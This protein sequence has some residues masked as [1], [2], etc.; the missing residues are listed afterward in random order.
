M[1]GLTEEHILTP[2][3]VP[4][5]AVAEPLTGDEIAPA[6]QRYLR[7]LPPDDDDWADPLGDYDDETETAALAPPEAEPDLESAVDAVL[8]EN[9]LLLVP[10]GRVAEVVP[11]DL[12]P[13][14]DLYLYVSKANS[15][16]FAQHMWVFKRAEAGEL[17]LAHFWPVSTGRERREGYFTTTPT[18]LYKLDPHR[19]KRIHYSSV[20]DGARMPFAM[21]LDYGY[22]DR[23]SGLAIHGTM[24][25]TYGRLGSRASGGC[26]RVATDNAR[27]LFNLI[28]GSYRGQVPAFAFDE[29]NGHTDRSGQIERDE[30][31]KPVFVEGLRALLIV[32]DFGGP[33]A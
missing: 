25:S 20:W 6:A 24:R 15:G 4:G 2:A 19:F 26:I 1:R 28:Q 29:I 17:R 7:I 14:F 10:S 9:G 3:N 23:R 27:F 33:G 8:G 16:A 18:G 5:E 30:E 11:A 13:H 21:F 22:S 31:G 32:D 12:M